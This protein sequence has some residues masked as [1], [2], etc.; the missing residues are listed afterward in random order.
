MPPH[1]VLAPGTATQVGSHRCPTLRPGQSYC[2][3]AEVV[4]EPDKPERREEERSFGAIVRSELPCGNLRS[5]PLG[6]TRV[7]SLDAAAFV[8][9]GGSPPARR[10]V[11]SGPDGEEF[12]P[13]TS[14]S[15]RNR[16]RAELLTVLVSGT[17]RRNVLGAIASAKNDR[18]FP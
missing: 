17:L 9:D 7:G 18:N 14:A 3:R 6:P 4:I 8:S 13:D 12:A 15:A 11:W 16:Y 10:G 2:R 5:L 1:S